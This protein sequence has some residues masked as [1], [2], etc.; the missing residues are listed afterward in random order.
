[1][2]INKI[3]SDV[4]EPKRSYDADGFFVLKASVLY[5]LKKKHK[6]SE[7]FPSI[8][9]EIKKCSTL[10]MPP[11]PPPP[12]APC[13]PL[14]AGAG[15]RVASSGHHNRPQGRPRPCTHGLR[16]KRNEATFPQ[17]LCKWRTPRVSVT[18]SWRHLLGPLSPESSEVPGDGAHSADNR[19][20]RLFPPPPTPHRAPEGPLG[21]RCLQ[22]GGLPR[23]LSVSLS[24]TGR[25]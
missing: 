15:L 6:L 18:G 1:M 9:R 7:T 20:Q 24:G 19:C 8:F 16:Q 22:P 25:F 2:G 21:C 11:D 17:V 13:Q 4:R 14:P 23:S 3:R 10:K 5:L 12:P